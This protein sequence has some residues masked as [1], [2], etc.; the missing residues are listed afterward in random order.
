MPQRNPR[1]KRNRRLLREG[2]SAAAEREAAEK[3]VL[4]ELEERLRE[5]RRD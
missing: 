3:E 1:R 4:R 2:K 5:T